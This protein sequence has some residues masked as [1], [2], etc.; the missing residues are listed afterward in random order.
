VKTWGNA[1]PNY[2][3]PEWSKAF[4]WTTNGPWRNAAILTYIR[5][6]YN[7]PTD[8]PFT[9]QWAATTLAQYD[10]AN[11]FTNPFLQS[12]FSS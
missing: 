8:T 4:A 5:A 11:L 10:K 1:E 7:Q 2:L 9:F 12:L 3:R 6:L